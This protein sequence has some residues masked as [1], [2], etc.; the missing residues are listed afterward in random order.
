MEN[1]GKTREQA[2]SA[3]DVDLETVLTGLNSLSNCMTQLAL[4]TQL[5]LC[6]L[7][8]CVGSPDKPTGLK[9]PG[10]MEAAPPLPDLILRHEEQSFAAALNE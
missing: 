10:G 9:N 7:I 3:A 1:A 4:R 6:D 2:P 5:R 8:V